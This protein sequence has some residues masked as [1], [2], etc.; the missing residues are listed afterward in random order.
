MSGLRTQL[1]EIKSNR[2]LTTD[3]CP[4]MVEAPGTAPGSEWLI[5]KAI[6]RHSRFAPARIYIGLSGGK[7]KIIA[8]TTP[9]SESKRV[10]VGSSS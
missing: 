1:S 6:Y 8:A 2:F 3:I 4:L 9:K 10:Y 5:T 7:K